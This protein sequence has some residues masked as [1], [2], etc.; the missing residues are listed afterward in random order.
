VSGQEET[1]RFNSIVDT[2]SVLS[3]RERHRSN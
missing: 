2:G 1:I 3:T